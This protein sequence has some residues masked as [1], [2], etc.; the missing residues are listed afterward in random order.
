MRNSIPRE[1]ARRSALHGSA[2]EAGACRTRITVFLDSTSHQLAQQVNGAFGEEGSESM[3]TQQGGSGP[4]PVSR[5]WIG[6]ASVG[7]MIAFAA[8]MYVKIEFGPKWAKEDKERNDNIEKFI[9]KMEQNKQQ[10]RSN[11]ELPQDWGQ[12][13]K[14][15]QD[16]INEGVKKF[17]PR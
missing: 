7:L 5:V 12:K 11:F 2:D 1:T 13:E 14:E 9:Q 15:R 3:A 17:N 8:I 16:A 10:K 4:E 6:L